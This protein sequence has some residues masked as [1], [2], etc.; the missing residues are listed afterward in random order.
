MAGNSRHREG[1]F[2][3]AKYANSQKPI[4][5]SLQVITLGEHSGTKKK[6]KRRA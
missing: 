6:N 4:K 1:L 5:R 2:D 3:R